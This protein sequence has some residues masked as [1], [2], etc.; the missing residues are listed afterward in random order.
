[1][2]AISNHEFL[3][4]RHEPSITLYNTIILIITSIYVTT[5]S[6][7]SL[8]G[9]TLTNRTAGASS[10]NPVF[11]SLWRNLY[12]M[13]NKLP[14]L[15]TVWLQNATEQL[16]INPLKTKRRLLYLKPR[17]YRAVNTFHLGYKNQSVYAVSGTSRC[18]FS[19]KYKTHKYSVS[20][21]HSL[22]YVFKCLSCRNYGL[23]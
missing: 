5:I 17:P 20:R 8:C 7:I 14:S 6:G 23:S 2:N 1:M 16:N 12:R 21:T 13:T 11:S 4:A 15:I 19:D 22:R 9:W 3:M 10:N 18:L